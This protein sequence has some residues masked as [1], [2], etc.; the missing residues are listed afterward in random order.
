MT[1][2]M[3]IKVIHS[4]PGR[5]RIRLNIF[6][7]SVADMKRT[8]KNH[9]GISE[10]NFNPYSKSML[11]KYDPEETSQEELMIRVAVYISMENDL[12]PVRVFS[13]T[14]VLE[15][16]ESAFLSGFLILV[17]LVSRIIPQ[18]AGFRN[19]LD[20]IAGIGTA[21][22]IFDH[23]Y[24]EFKE[25]G[26]FDPEVLSVIYLLSSFAQGKF[27]PAALFTWVA[28]FGRHLVR[29]SSKNVEIQPRLVVDSPKNKPQ[30]EVV[31]NP[32]SQLPGRKMLFNILPVLIMNAAVGNRGNIAGTLMDEIRKVSLDHGEV[33]EGFG[34]LKNGMPIRI[35]YN[36][37]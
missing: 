23:G 22:S 7:K 18:S 9:V 5:V 12:Q 27:L 33:L 35:K 29:Y 34:K 15:M 19:I 11:L 24:D 25:R 6:P 31:V 36:K 3:K 10:I 8:V 17:S 26:H 13:D 20:W 32:I 30:Y 16:S 2:D 14:K 1:E 21:Y 37:N 4:L 28:T